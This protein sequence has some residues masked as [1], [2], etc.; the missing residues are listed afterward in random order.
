M[1]F[2]NYNCFFSTKSIC[3][4]NFSSIAYETIIVRYNSVYLY[5][6]PSYNDNAERPWYSFITYFIFRRRRRSIF[7]CVVF[8]ADLADAERKSLY[9]DGRTNSLQV[10]RPFSVVNHTLVVCLIRYKSPLI[11]HHG[12]AKEIISKSLRKKKH[13]YEIKYLF[14]LFTF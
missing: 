9:W 2:C 13:L 4:R 10:R 8:L 6:R 14:N 1:T 5:I 11:N 7:A 12:K 3:A